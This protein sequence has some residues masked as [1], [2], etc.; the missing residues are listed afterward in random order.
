MKKQS[1]WALGVGFLFIVVVTTAFDVVMH[2]TGVFPPW[3]ETQT[4]A[5]A[6][7]ALAYR[8]LIGMAGAWL[9]ARVAPHAPL[10]HAL[11]LGAIGTVLAA[12]GAVS[13]WNMDLGPRWYAVSLV[14][15]AL[16]QCWAGAR[17]WQPNTATSTHRPLHLS[18]H[19]R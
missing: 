3:G 15:L 14:L 12:V 1:V 19:I 18:A 9:T 8:I 6:A 10:K 13:T 16:P 2:A 11:V 7:L 4:Q 5:G 17:L